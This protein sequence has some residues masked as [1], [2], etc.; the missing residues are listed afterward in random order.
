[1]VEPTLETSLDF[2]TEDLEIK[3]EEEKC[4]AKLISQSSEYPTL[5]LIEEEFTV[6]RKSTCNFQIQDRLVSGNHCKIYRQ[7]SNLGTCVFL[8]D[9]SSNGTYV[10]GQLVGKNNT[11]PLQD[12]SEIVLIKDTPEKPAVQFIFREFFTRNERKAQQKDGPFQ[13]YEITEP[14]GSGAFATVKLAT[15]LINKKQFAI[16]IID[17]KK[18]AKHAGSRKDNLMDEVEI[19]KKLNHPNI[20]SI[21]DVFD[22]ETTL[23]IVLELVTGGELFD[24]II[25]EGHFPE[26]ECKELF[27]QLVDAIAYLH[28][29]GIAHRDLKPENLMFADK[30]FKQL[31]IGDFGL[32]FF[33][34][35]SRKC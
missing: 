17:K 13:L 11:I 21:Q 19:L 7:I 2:S 29:L 9:L 10:N 32:V 26:N 5:N 27:Q 8:K 18:Y 15:H 6:G 28:G 14:L 25:E 33:F 34:I 12:A 1:M 20:I 3:Q 30:T 31:K 16:K 4:W 35:F 22:T 23:F 24:K